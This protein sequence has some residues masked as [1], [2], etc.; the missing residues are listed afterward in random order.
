MSFIK[1][2]YGLSYSLLI[3]LGL[4]IC[5]NFHKFFNNYKSENFLN[6]IFSDNTPT[7]TFNPNNYYCS[8]LKS[9]NNNLHSSNNSN[10]IEPVYCPDEHPN[11]PCQLVKRCQCTE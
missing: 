9:R 2:N 11:I 1:T 6:N 3:L 4:L 7:T 8:H 5:C 10:N